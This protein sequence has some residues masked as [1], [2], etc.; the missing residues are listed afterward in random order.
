[1]PNYNN[2]AY[3]LDA[4]RSVADQSFLDFECIIVD[5]ASTDNSLDIIEK[6]IKT[7][8]RFRLI[9]LSNNVGGAEARNIGL[10]STVGEYVGFLDSDDFFSPTAIESLL[11]AIKK[12]DSDVAIGD[13]FT[14]QKEVKYKKNNLRMNTDLIDAK[15]WTNP[16]DAFID[17]SKKP[18]I[19]WVWR[20]LFKYSV[21]KNI[22]F[23]K[24]MRNNHDLE[25]VLSSLPYT[26]KTVEINSIVAWHRQ[27]ETALSS[28]KY[29]TSDAGLIS[30]FHTNIIIG[31]RF[32]SIYPKY[33]M[34]Q[35]QN[36]LSMAFYYKKLLP[37]IL[38]KKHI[39]PHT[40]SLILEYWNTDI[41][42]IKKTPLLRRWKVWFWLN[43]IAVSNK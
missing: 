42:N 20:R 36:N 37:A 11:W 6:F 26:N 12:Y 25:F 1:M 35:L 43:L 13:A 24:G 2:R 3:I 14:V 30:S 18:G 33:F 5:D 41:F 21:I 39:S 9:K 40:A 7:D 10:S 23:I 32:D 38:N 28:E 19:P 15:V 29:M 22:K 31:K 27:H 8:E 34:K 17:I 4:M 16:F